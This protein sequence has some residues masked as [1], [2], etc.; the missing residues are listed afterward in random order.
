MAEPIPRGVLTISTTRAA[1]ILDVTPRHVVNLIRTG[2]LEAVDLA[3]RG[4]K[5]PRWF[6]TRESLMAFVLRRKAAAEGASKI[7]GTDDITVTTSVATWRHD[8]KRK[9]RPGDR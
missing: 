1:R 8:A 2:E 6:T 5:R 9:V 3:Q 4:A 7:Y